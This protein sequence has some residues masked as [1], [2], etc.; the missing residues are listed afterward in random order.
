MFANI[1][2]D[3]STEKLDRTFEYIIPP[4]LEGKVYPGVCVDVP[5]GKG[6]TRRTGYVIEVNDKPGFDLARLKPLLGISDKAVPI[7]AKLIALAAWM[8]KNYGGSFNQALKTVLP[9][10]EKTRQNR[11]RTIKLLLPSDK[12]NELLAEFERKHYTAKLRLLEAL[13]EENDLDY[14]MAVK[15]LHVTPAVIKGLTEAGILT[16]TEENVYRN[17]N[18]YDSEKGDFH[19]LNEEQQ[20]VCDGIENE[21][22]S[23]DMRPALIKGVTGSGKTEVYMELIANAAKKGKCSILLIPE[24][25]LTFQTI[26][27]FYNRFGDRVSLMHSRLS[28]GERYDQFLR[29]KNGELD[30]MIG[31]RSA[32]FTPFENLGYII[33]DEEHESSYK[34]EPIPRYHARETAIERAKLSNA[35][36]VLGSATPSLESFY[37]AKNGEFSFYE[38]KNR[39]EN[40]AMPDCT[41]VDLR[42]ELRSGNRSIISRKLYAAIEERLQRK[43]QIMLFINRRGMAGAVSCRSCGEAIKCPHCDVSLSLHNN[44]MLMCHYCGYK[45]VQT[46]SCPSCGSP[47]IGAFKAGTQ[48]IEEVIKASFPN[49]KTLR[50]DYDTTRTKDGYDNI[51]SAFANEEADI[52]IG[53]QMIVKGHD[54]P[55][56]TLVGIIA[57]DMSLYEAD[58]RSAERTFSLLTQASGRAGR[59]RTKGEVI[60]QTYQP[61][62]YAIECAKTGDFESFFDRE[63]S[64]RSLMK[65]PPV[66]NMLLIIFSSEKYELC[67]ELSKTAAELITKECEVRNVKNARVIG[68]SDA[69]ILK[70]KDIYR[71]TLY[72]KSADY[73]FLS[74]VPELIAKLCDEKRFEDVGVVY[75][76]NPMDSF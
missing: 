47:F 56:V 29:A 63:I 19:K 16:V 4:E 71:K 54:F 35:K 46:K 14:D 58:Y 3:I 6:D 73:T 40:R 31:P 66:W 43:E 37:R 57:A 15:K 49:A 50:M 17:P 51:L 20:A 65:Y 52:L 44:G 53:T 2:I 67:D 61:E 23:G 25:S 9:V 55:S 26:R 75:D 42:E 38:L 12:A 39:V 5:F 10:H 64:Y 13:I 36:V 68:P 62:H 70:L 11:K 7:E 30:V 28:K 76:F 69:G 60:I 24:I 59:G 45:R 1:I 74:D 8:K 72:V 27:R 18:V 32:L 41:I 33:I 22:L 34:S 21:I 48:K